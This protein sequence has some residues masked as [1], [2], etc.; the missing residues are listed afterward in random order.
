MDL[1]LERALALCEETGALEC[2][3]WG[4]YGIWG[5]VIRQWLDELLPEDAA[6]R[7][8]GRVELLVT[9]LNPGRPAPSLE[10]PD[11][12]PHP[13]P[14]PNPNP[15][16]DRNRNPSPSPSPCPSPSPSP[17]PSPNPE[18]YPYPYP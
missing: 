2:G 15:T 8:D 11:P 18:P 9:A 5:G 16:V 13:S 10:L 6:Q 1:A 4:L 14:S 12:H 7:C 3:A 17:S